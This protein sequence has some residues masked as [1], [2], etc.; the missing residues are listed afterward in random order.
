MFHLFDNSSTLVRV[1]GNLTIISVAVIFAVQLSLSVYERDKSDFIEYTSP[2]TIMDP[3]SLETRLNFSPGNSF[4][5]EYHV[6]KYEI[7]CFAEYITF[8][9]GPVSIQFPARKSQFLG[10]RGT[11]S[12]NNLRV[13]LELPTQIPK[14]EYE[15]QLVVYP[16]CDGI[17][18]D[19]FTLDDG[20]T[21]IRVL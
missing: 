7:G 1:L 4:V 18:R 2:P 11:S 9:N 15:I 5:V 19:A 8:A 20:Q 13:L 14:G 16:T 17:Q 21:K 3:I 10:Q 6:K 12:E